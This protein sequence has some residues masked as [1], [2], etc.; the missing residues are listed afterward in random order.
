MQINSIADVRRFLEH[1]IVYVDREKE[2]LAGLYASKADSILDYANYIR[3]DDNL[4]T[5]VEK[6]IVLA[7]KNFSYTAEG[8]VMQL[9]DTDKRPDLFHRPYLKALVSDFC[10]DKTIIKPRQSENSQGEI[11]EN[12]YMLMTMPNINILHLFP[13][14]GM[15]NEIAKK[16]VDVIVRQSPNIFKRMMRPYNIT[17]KAADNNSFYSLLGSF[18]DSGGRGQSADKI[19]YD[20]FE[21]QNP[22]I[23]EV[24]AES[25]SH[26]KIQREV[27]L[28]TPTIPNGPI[29]RAYSAS[30]QFVWKFKCECC[31]RW[32]SFEF[33]YNLINYFGKETVK[34]ESPE[35]YDRLK[36][37]YL[38]CRYCKTYVNRTGEFYLKNSLWVPKHKHLVGVRNGYAINQMML[39][40]KTG[41]EILHKYHAFQFVEQ[42]WNEIMGRAFLSEER[43]ISDD[44][45]E[46][47]INYGLRNVVSNNNFFDRTSVGTDWGK[48]ESWTIVGGSRSDANDDRF[49]VAYAAR[50]DNDHLISVGLKPSELSHQKRVHQICTLF[51]ADISVN[52]ANGIGADKNA[53][54]Y[55]ALP[56]GTTYG[57]FYDTQGDQ[58]QL[59]NKDFRATKY[60]EPAWNETK[61][62][63]TLNRTVAFKL[64]LTLIQEGEIIFPAR[65]PIIDQMIEH[66]KA[67]NILTRKTDDGREYEVMISTGADHFA[68]ALLYSYFGWKK[69]TKRSKNP[70]GAIGDDVF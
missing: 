68:H 40:W 25:M 31:K 14:A 62:I 55:E 30:C 23:K 22:K 45:F 36:K 46:R 11:N 60:I 7:G 19:T 67:C 34:M 12:L 47:C 51:N 15:A 26:S 54:L 18:N 13:T 3:G 65:D 29:D 66:I 58:K 50:I 32:Q 20:E 1:D 9:A 33:P 28:S 64:L 5:W 24:Y 41:K 17:T 39:P 6:N 21:F 38:G 57:A 16:K 27:K 35:Y 48:T 63:V 49:T 61:R 59:I 2:S 10:H 8:S 70:L 42:F 44:V 69:L 53:Y 56:D 43:R 52:D 4:Q 37:V